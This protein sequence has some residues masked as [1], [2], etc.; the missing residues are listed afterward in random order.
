MGGI[1]HTGWGAGTATMTR[2]PNPSAPLAA[3][4]SCELVMFA[5]QMQAHRAGWK[6]FSPRHPMDSN[7]MAWW[8]ALGMDGLRAHTFSRVTVS[9]ALIRVTY[10]KGTPREQA[11]L[12]EC[13]T[14][15]R[16]HLRTEPRIWMEL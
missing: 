9:E 14:E 8:P 13:F 3:E 5:G 15:A 6:G 12:Q 2:D 10:E 4:R 7:L 16:A 1:G 11:H